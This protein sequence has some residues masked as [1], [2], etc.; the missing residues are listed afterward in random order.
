[1][2]I[3]YID[4]NKDDT[5][6]VD[7][8]ELSIDDA[9][10]VRTTNFFPFGRVVKTPLSANSII[11]FI[12]SEFESIIVDLLKEEYKDNFIEEINKYELNHFFKR[13]TSHYCINGIV[14]SHAAG[15]FSNRSFVILEPLKYHINDINIKSLRAEDT[16]F[17]G[18]VAL[19]IEA[20]ILM[21]EK[22]YNLLK[23]NPL[24][25]ND[26]LNFNIIVYNGNDQDLAVKKALNVLGYNSFTINS[27]G[28]NDIYDSN[29]SAYQMLNFI[30]KLAND[31]GISTDR[32]FG[33]AY[34][35]QEIE[36]RCQEEINNEIRIIEIITTELG[37]EISEFNKLKSYLVKYSRSPEFKDELKSLFKEYGL[38]NMA[39]LFKK[40]N[41]NFNENLLIEKNNK[42]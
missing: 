41:D 37:K 6:V 17:E 38:D 8:K 33:S 19:S 36:Q 34:H 28:Y 3:T 18:D 26:L 23:N 20:S 7:K 29:E 22:M 31:Y 35:L 40:F 9:V 4:T 30:F 25:I 13:N 32:H 16:Y 27:N 24:Y 14:G 11:R 5:I 15:D 39:L 1:M 2:S 12:P 42:L 21:S 10:L